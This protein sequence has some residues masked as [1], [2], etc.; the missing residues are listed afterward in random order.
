MISKALQFP[1]KEDKDDDKEK[2]GKKNDNDIDE[3]DDTQEEIKPEDL[4]ID[5]R[6]KFKLYLEKL[7]QNFQRYIVLGKN[8]T[9]DESILQFK[10]RNNMKFYIPM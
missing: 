2:K 10:G 3:I 1:E 7:V 8:I 4:R 5:H 9:N 6:K